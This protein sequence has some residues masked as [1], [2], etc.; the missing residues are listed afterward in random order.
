MKKVLILGGGGCG[1]ILA[2]SLNLNDYDITIIDKN[3]Y[4]Y[5]QP[6]YLYV[7]FK[8]SNR[9]IWKRIPELIKPGVKFFK[10]EV[11]EINLNDRYV[12][13]ISGKKF[14]YDFVTICTGTA[15]DVS[16]IPGLEEVHNEYG[17]Y[18]S[19]YENA[20]RLWSKFK[21]FNGGTFVLAQASTICKCP[22]SMLEGILMAEE[23]INK[24]G[25]KDKTKFVF[26]TPFPRAY[27]AEPMNRVVEPIVKE[28]GIE[29]IP[30][31][32][33]D[34]VDPVNKKIISM[35][36]EEVKYDFPA[37]VPPCRGVKI[38]YE[39]E[40]VL[41]DDRFVK[42]DKYTMKVT[43]FD[44]AFALGDTNNLPT[45]K[46]GVTAHLEAKVV[47]DMFHGLDSKFNGR[48][49]CPF[50]L[51]YGL[52]T[53]VIADYDHPVVPY[54]PDRLKHLM[55]MMMARIYWM[56]LQSQIDNIFDLYF[57]LTKPEKLLELYGAEEK[58]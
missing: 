40:N 8:G 42:V 29:V 17:D 32:N 46:T 38:K 27:P 52:G 37:I 57:D 3:E 33:L 45:S 23:Y 44:D 9:K 2:N 21:D 50:D 28:R 51:G 43:G 39:P 19:T 13:T 16:G 18:H 58:V 5:Y 47:A 48:I 1:I 30:F 14:D 31:F 15:P 10:D 7:A 20:K 25:L 35:E 4:H 49:N 12:K 22:P 36:G 55:K 53:F 24:K 56:T 41:D 11:T 34:S 6:W 26:L 54:P